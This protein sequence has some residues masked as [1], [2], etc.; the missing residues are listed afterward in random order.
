MLRQK[1]ECLEMKGSDNGA[2]LIT[3]I[4]DLWMCGLRDA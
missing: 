3:G 1:G 2:Y 4:G